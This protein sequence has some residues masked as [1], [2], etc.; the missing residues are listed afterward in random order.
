MVGQGL[1]DEVNGE[2]ELHVQRACTRREYG[3]FEKLCE[4]GAVVGA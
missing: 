3:S 4:G 1:C 2:S